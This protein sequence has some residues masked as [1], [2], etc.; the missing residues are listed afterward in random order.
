MPPGEPSPALPCRGIFVLGVDRSG[1]S[2]LSDLVCRW[3]AYPG[4]ADVLGETDSYNPQGY[5]E[6][7]PMQKLLSDLTLSTGVLEWDPR[8]HSL[9]KLRAHDPNFRRQAL[10]L[11]AGMEKEGGPWLW[12]EPFLCLHMPFWEQVIPAPVCVMTVRNPQDSALSFT[13]MNLRSLA[14]R[15][16]LTSYFS[17]R[18][19]KF[20]LAVLEYFESNP[21]HLVVQYEELLRDPAGQVRRL[22]RFLDQRFGQVGGEEER[23]AAMLAAIDPKLWRNRAA[24][25]FFEIPEAT[26][27]QKELLRYLHLRAADVRPPFDPERYP[28]PPHYQEYLENFLL[29]STKISMSAK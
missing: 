19:Q 12:K 15:I 16:S 6:Y 28:F 13:R 2:L 18:W 5:F 17:L 22:C 23:A 11:V 26:E 1:T 25:S 14:D 3:G 24:S 29:L 9:L 27:A 7:S 21:E 4:E 8:F 10:A 20:M